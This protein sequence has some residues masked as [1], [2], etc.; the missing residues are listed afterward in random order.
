MEKIKKNK[1]GLCH[2]VFDVIH[3]GHLN[4]F[5][6][7]KSLCDYLI[8]SIT[9]DK[10]VRK[11]MNQPL[12][13]ENQRADFLRS[14]KYIDEV[15]I[16]KSESASDSIKKFKPDFYIKGPDYKINAL[17]E[18]G[19]IYLEKKLVKKY[20]GQIIYTN[21]KKYSSSKIINS[22]AFSLN[23]IQSEFIDN[24]KKKY[25]LSYI[26]S[27][28]KKLKNVKPIVLGELII[29][30]YCYGN[31]IGKASKEPHLVLSR[32]KEES[33]IGGSAAIAKNISNFTKKVTL[34]SESGNEKKFFKFFK[35]KLG[36][37][38]KS[39]FFKPYPSY[40]TIR[41][42]R[43]IDNVNSYK[44]LGYYDLPEVNKKINKI[45][46]YKLIKSNLIKNNLLIVSDFGHNFF[47]Q[48]IIDLVN[49]FK[50]CYKSANVQINSA[51]LGSQSLKKYK[52]LNA[53][54]INEGELRHEYRD[55]FSSI[56]TLGKLIKKNNKIQNVIITRGKNGAVMIDNKSRIINVPAFANSSVDKIGA[57]DSL[58][59]VC[60]IALSAG[61][62]GYLSLFLG[63]LSA[64]E[65]V[66]FQGNKFSINKNIIER[67]ISY[68]YR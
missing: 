67:Y 61:I 26:S 29:D 30:T 44:L 38:V 17:D 22:K 53:L 68:I 27:E 37:S 8:V 59:A 25:S 31:A 58:F 19:K 57:G 28:L 50:G 64:A 23:K 33:Y 66:K 5:K 20:K 45:K 47:D 9:Q 1:V 12:F 2:G 24:L 65:S 48:K 3:I 62:D 18:T 14:I 42:T 16:C 46:L 10:F 55:K 49:N 43:Y 4:H 15:Y 21:D 35:E 34:I 52:N 40:T 32:L 7:A 6:S 63:S 11:G 60:S 36:M 51:N 39:I 41:K 13:T 56:E 54:F